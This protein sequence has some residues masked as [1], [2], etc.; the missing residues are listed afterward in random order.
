VD[1]ITPTTATRT[2]ALHCPKCADLDAWSHHDW[3]DGV[4]V[5]RVQPLDMLIVRTQN[6]TYEITILCPQSG[7]VLVRGGRFFPE[8]TRVC[9]AGCSLGGSFLKLR[10]IYVGFCL[11]L[12]LDCQMIM[13]TRV[14]SIA[15]VRQS[16]VQ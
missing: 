16:G 3:S 15:H 14:Q 10:G 7:N 11:E 8:F 5:D 6:S 12:H 2:E 9:V 13:T 1:S 4:Q